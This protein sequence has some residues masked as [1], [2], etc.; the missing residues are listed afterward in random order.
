MANPYIEHLI[1]M[2]FIRTF[3]LHEVMILDRPLIVRCDLAVDPV[4]MS[5]ILRLMSGELWPFMFPKGVEGM[6]QIKSFEP[7]DSK[8]AIDDKRME[9]WEEA[10]ARPSQREWGPH[11]TTGLIDFHMEGTDQVVTLPIN[12]HDPAVEC[13]RIED[14]GMMEDA[15]GT[16]MIEIPMT[17]H[18][19][20]WWVYR[21][22]EIF[23]I[24][25]PHSPLV[26]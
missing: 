7:L 4:D 15:T 18:Y 26:P 13:A 10:K 1:M 11:N 2:A 22:I 21:W 6:I 24:Y 5:L 23:L 19:C 14:F 8:V 17:P 3:N 12:I 16:R 20:L 25:S 9:M